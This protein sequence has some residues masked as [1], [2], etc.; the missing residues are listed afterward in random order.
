[1]LIIFKF[2]IFLK[3]YLGIS[4]RID[5]QLSRFV[6]NGYYIKIKK[7]LLHAAPFHEFPIGTISKVKKIVL[8]S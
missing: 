8:G 6:S 7:E 2:R 3:R 4:K 1:M 5:F